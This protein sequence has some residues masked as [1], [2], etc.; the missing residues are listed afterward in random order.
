MKKKSFI[1]ALALVLVFAVAVGGVV[2]WLTAKT[3]DVVNTF[4]VGNI[5]IDL[6]ETNNGEE[7]TSNSYKMVPGNTIIKDPYV[8][9]KADSEKCYLFVKVTKT[10]DPDTYLN[11]SVD[12]GVWTAVPGHDG[13]YYC[14]V[15]AA[16]TNQTFYVLKDKKVT[17]KD[18]VTKDM[19]DKLT[20]ATYPKLTFTAAAVQ[21]DNIDDVAAAFAKLPVEFT[22]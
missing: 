18:D 2:A 16:N 14:V 6:K 17:V 11:Y 5:N 20:E 22:R 12:N 8:T 4:T 3:G 19:M 15:D 7:V 9:V 21:F 10:N 13:Y 1:M